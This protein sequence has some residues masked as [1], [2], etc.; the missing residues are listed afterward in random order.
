MIRHAK[1][2]HASTTNAASG[3]QEVLKVE[4]GEAVVPRGIN[5]ASINVLIVGVRD[6]GV[7][8]GRRRTALVVRGQSPERRRGGSGSADRRHAVGDGWFGCEAE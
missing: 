2:G 4:V 5:G 7:V 1:T 8:A 6:P 3:D